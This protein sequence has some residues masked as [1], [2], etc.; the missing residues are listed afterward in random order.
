MLELKSIK[1]E[2][3]MSAYDNGETVKQGF[4]NDSGLYWHSDINWCYEELYFSCQEEIVR[5]NLEDIPTIIKVLTEFS[6]DV[7]AYKE[8]NKPDSTKSCE[9]VLDEV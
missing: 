2:N 8:K 1:S 3:D 7:E 9:E 4:V 5:F 6:R